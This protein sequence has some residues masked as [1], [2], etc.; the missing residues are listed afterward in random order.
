[1]K[2]KFY[3][4]NRG[5]TLLELIL[6]LGIA[7]ILL[8]VI[9]PR[10]WRARSDAQYNLIRQAAVELGNW[11]TEWSTR[12]LEAQTED[13]TCQ[14]NDYLDSL[15]GYVGGRRTG[16]LHNNWFGTVNAMTAG[17]CRDAGNPVTFTV[18]RIM[19]GENQPRNPF[20]GLAYLHAAHDGSKT[21]PGLLY[22]A[23]ATD[24]EG[25]NNYYFVFTGA[26]AV[27]ASD[28]HAG[29]GDGVPPTYAGLRNGVFVSRT[30]P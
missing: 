30:R 20:T 17:S 4:N 5:F 13:D 14:H 25:F 24:S 10:A 6:V 26:D 29:M 22:L 16:S 27:S 8:V 7:G 19:P 18:A 23:A 21:E 11:G 12:N 2:T 9:L 28:W 15:V 3:K 1:M